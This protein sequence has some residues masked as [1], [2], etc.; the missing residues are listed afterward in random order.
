[1]VL[2][3]SL[4]P[5]SKKITFVPVERPS[6]EIDNVFHASAEDKS[7]EENFVLMVSET[8]EPGK[9]E[10]LLLRVSS[11]LPAP[12]SH[13]GG[14]AIPVT[15][16]GE[17]VFLNFLEEEPKNIEQIPSGEP[18]QSQE[19]PVIFSEVPESKNEELETN[20]NE[21][22]TISYTPEI[23]SSLNDYNVACLPSNLREGTFPT[24]A[25]ENIELDDNIPLQFRKDE[26][27][28]FSGRLVMDS[29]P[30]TL[31]I[32]YDK[33]GDTEHIDQKAL[34][35]EVKDGIFSAPVSFSE[36]GQYLLS[37]IPGNSGYA[38][39]QEISV[40]A[41]ECENGMGK[42][43]I[44]PL[45][46]ETNIEEGKGKLSWKDE[47][48]NLFHVRFSQGE[49]EK[50][51]YLMDT[52]EFFPP[53]SEFESFSS[54]E[55]LVS[56]RSAKAL[57][58]ALNRTS[59]WSATLSKKAELVQHYNRDGNKLQN[60]KVTDS[61]APKKTLKVSG[62]ADVP[63]NSDLIVIDPDE[64]FHRI[65][66][67]ITGNTFLG[68]F[69]VEKPG[70]HIVEVNQNDNISLFM[71]ASSPEGSLPLLPDFFDLEKD[72]LP[73][74]H[75][76][77]ELPKIML[78]LV[79]GERQKRGMHELSYDEHLEGLAEYR[80]NDMCERQYFGHVDPDGKGAGDYAENF[81]ITNQNIGEN[82]V[83]GM[84]IEALHELLMYS[85]DHR[86]LILNPDFETV[87]F[88]FCRSSSDNQKIIGTQ[89][90]GGSPLSE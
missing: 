54:G 60:V 43:S 28:T 69:S 10:V 75:E 23:P 19:E 47:E 42:F 9:K 90:F 78:D 32:F 14:E 52:N 89:I 59:D 16:S 62:T 65:P 11:A 25:F 36:T 50:N 46:F 56:I 34:L 86:E 79:N 5:Y 61:I 21:E 88:G 39:P 77:S 51:F 73:E 30:E 45:D 27:R 81:F 29:P 35:V 38:V 6:E 53:L 76:L 3:D 33:K 64:V 15:K 7:E 68:K 67:T 83:S 13:S 71:G 57:D 49:L 74:S 41:P 66:M 17:T 70:I 20:E 80:S 37:L 84:N 26:V 2:E 8:G 72:Q 40:K 1:M 4:D 22:N 31:V 18:H 24:D 87:G 44:P 58:N 82:I 12:V 48:N 85:A 55:I 63:L